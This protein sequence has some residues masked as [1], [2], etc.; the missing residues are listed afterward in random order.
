[1]LKKI[2]IGSVILL[3]LIAVSGFLIL[4][5]VL[6]PTL[7]K[8]L[9]ENLNRKVSIED[10]DINPFIIS[11]KI[12]GFVIRDM[13]DRETFASVGEL[14]INLQAAESLLKRAFVVEEISINKPY[15]MIIRQS[16]QK[17][18]FSDLIKDQDVK[19]KEDV[20][21]EEV[22]K[23]AFNFFVG[24]I[25]V[26]GG[27]IDLVDSPKKKQHALTDISFALPFLSNMKKTANI[28]V[29]PC[30]SANI[31]GTPLVLEGR[32]KPFAGTLETT[33]DIDLKGI[34]IPYYM[35]YMPKEIAIKIPSGSLDVKASLSYLQSRDKT[36][37]M[38][39]S[40]TVGLNN[41]SITDEKNIPL[42]RFQQ[43][44]VNVAESRFL[45]QSVHLSSVSLNSP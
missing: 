12:K 39:V 36:F 30:F 4:P 41:F 11:A 16:G 38:K 35:E 18:N 19:E 5:A 28:F 44:T 17:Y 21:K 33:F 14:Y 1:M 31:N 13:E 10:I 9:A 8:K 32:S 24:N 26:G 27:R 6:K 45:E 22:K 37:V 20:K 23:D 43:L 7:A 2:I 34:D 15:V 42:L 29:N 3:I 25:Q 40:G